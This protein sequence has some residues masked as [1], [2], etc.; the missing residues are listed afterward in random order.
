MQTLEKAGIVVKSEHTEI[1][2][3]GQAEKRRG[4]VRKGAIIHAAISPGETSQDMHDAFK[5]YLPCV[6]AAGRH[7][8]GRELLRICAYTTE[9]K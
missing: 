5:P 2:I 6:S 9:T 1:H 3:P 8:I 4:S 7:G